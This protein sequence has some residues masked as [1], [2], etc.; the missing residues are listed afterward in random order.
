MYIPDTQSQEDESGPASLSE[1]VIQETPERLLPAKGRGIQ[2]TKTVPPTLDSTQILDETQIVIEE[3]PDRPK[4]QNTMMPSAA[5]AATQVLES[6][7][8]ETQKFLVDE[9]P[10]KPF[11]QTEVGETLLMSADTT[12][13]EEEEAPTG[14]GSSS[15]QAVDSTLIIGETD[16]GENDATQIITEVDD[17][18]LFVEESPK[19]I[20]GTSP[21][22]GKDQDET[23]IVDEFDNTQPFVKVGDADRRDSEEATLLI[24]EDNI[25]VSWIFLFLLDVWK[26]IV[27]CVRVA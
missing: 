3:T 5:L 8:E 13:S 23:Q 9:A 14:A 2:F 26:Q 19:Q 17:T 16:G 1:T 10:N 22:T 21:L 4:K 18:Q 20:K 7:A 11:Q 24:S 12:V 27:E 15:T 25:E 6:E